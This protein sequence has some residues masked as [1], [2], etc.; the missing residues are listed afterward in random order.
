M[1]LSELIIEYRSEHGLSQRE[2]AA[3]C[4]LSH[5]FISILEKNQHPK[6]GKP[7]IP[8]IR[9]LQSIASAMGLTLYELLTTADD[10]D[11]P[12]GFDDFFAPNPLEEKKRRFLSEFAALSLGD[13]EK[14]LEYARFI[15]KDK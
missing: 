3:A 15:T 11:V 9:N 8:N 2:F 1:N 12:A 13:M 4:N 14:V 5:G 10:V 7:I 6:T